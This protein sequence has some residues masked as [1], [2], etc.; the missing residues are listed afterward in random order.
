MAVDSQHEEYSKNLTKWL[1]VRDCDEGSQAVKSRSAGSTNSGTLNGLAGTAYLPAPNANDNS[2]ENTQRYYAYKQRAN[3]VNFTAHTKEGLTGLV[4]RRK[5][6]IEAPTDIEYLIDNANGDGLTT[7]QMIKNATNEVLMIGRYGMLVDYPEAPQGLT[8]AEVRA[9]ELQANILSYPAES[10]INWR[11][12]MVGGVKKLTLVVLKEPRETTKD[13]FEYTTVC[14]HRVLLLKDIDGNMTYVQNLYDDNGEMVVWKVG[15]DNE[16]DIVTGDIIPRKSDGSMWSEIPFT[17][18]G[19]VNNDAVVDK[20]PLYDI[21][22]INISHYRNSADYEESSFMVGQPTPVLAGL[23]PSWVKDVLKEKVG[24]GSRAAIMLP[25]NGSADLLQANENQMPKAGM[26][27]KEQQMMKVG[28]NIIQDVGGNE[29]V[30]AVKIRFTGQNSKLGSII[31]NVEAAFLQCY[32]WAQE[33]MGGTGDSVITINKEFYDATL[34]PQ[35]IIAQIQLLDR[36]IIATND[37]RDNLRSGNI[38]KADRTNEDIEGEAEIGV[39]AG[40]FSE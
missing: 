12:E 10:V 16:G 20:A 36:G 34:D 30:D 13:G 29:T 25:E 11:S 6:S 26:E 19:S 37:L 8:D 35:L 31:Q 27:I 18:I 14:Y 23:T 1:L 9:M 15:E 22:E 40:D 3:F 7:D 38:I 2:Q 4:F 17:F 28:A 39:M 21:A 32:M 24:L 33:F 5:T